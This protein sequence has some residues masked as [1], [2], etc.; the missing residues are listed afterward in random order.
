V[1]LSSNSGCGRARDTLLERRQWRRSSSQWSLVI[2]TGTS[3]SDAVLVRLSMRARLAVTPDCR[4]CRASDTGAPASRRG[5]HGRHM[6]FRLH[7]RRAPNALVGPRALDV[8][9]VGRRGV[10]LRGFVLTAFGRCS[11][12]GGSLDSLHAARSIGGLE[13]ESEERTP[14]RCLVPRVSP[15]FVGSPTL[16]TASRA[17]T[18]DASAKPPAL[19]ARRRVNV[20]CCAVRS[21]SGRA[22]GAHAAGNQ[23][24]AAAVILWSGAER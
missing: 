19:R 8:Q 21:G 17:V 2:A 10:G 5:V 3:V 16:A 22:V 23:R 18:G 14:R 12:C 7:V 9:D 1:L 4:A 15:A 6:R 20:T 13:R 24:L 11:R